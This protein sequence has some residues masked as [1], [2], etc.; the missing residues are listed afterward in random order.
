MVGHQLDLDLV[1]TYNYHPTQKNTRC[2]DRRTVSVVLTTRREECGILSVSYG[3]DLTTPFFGHARSFFL[4][5]LQLQSTHCDDRPPKT[6]NKQSLEALGT[7]TVS[8]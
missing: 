6:I 1:T 5:C 7:T 8:N 2:F 3:F 4:L